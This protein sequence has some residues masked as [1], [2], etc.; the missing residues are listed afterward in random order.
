MDPRVRRISRG[1]R[2]TPEEVEHYRQV[3][4]E[5]EREKPAILEKFRRD[6]PLLALLSELRRARVKAGLSLSDIG[7]RT[8]IDRSYLSR[9]ETGARENPSLD[10]LSKYAQAVG[11]RMEI[12]LVDDTPVAE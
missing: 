12:R 6:H 4:E 3:R 8:G 7:E 9:L 2:L 10:M 11:K 5:I 1:R